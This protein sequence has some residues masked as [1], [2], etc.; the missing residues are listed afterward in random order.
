MLLLGT[1]QN[2]GYPIHKQREKEITMRNFITLADVREEIEE[3]KKLDEEGRKKYGEK[4]PKTPE[5]SEDFLRVG[6]YLISNDV[7]GDLGWQIIILDHNDNE[8]FDCNN[9]GNWY[10]SEYN[11]VGQEITRRS[12]RGDMKKF[13]YDDKGNEVVTYDEEGTVTW[14]TYDENNNHITTKDSEGYWSKKTY[15]SDGQELTH[16]D[17]YGGYSRA[18]YNENGWMIKYE[19][20]EWWEENEYSPEGELI[21]QKS[22]YKNR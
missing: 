9:R 4:L 14:K 15:N 11:E 12:S 3:L 7:S 10:E 22:D 19:D 13:I 1:K 21:S 17:S 18:E 8:L 20:E 16:D 6:N 5:N 2:K